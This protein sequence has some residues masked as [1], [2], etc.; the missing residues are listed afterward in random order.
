MVVSGP[1]SPSSL[2]RLTPHAPSAGTEVQLAVVIATDA[3]PVG[4]GTLRFT[5]EARSS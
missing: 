1:R 4:D 5:V 2:S 3:V